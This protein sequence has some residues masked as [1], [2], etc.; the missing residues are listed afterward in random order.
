LSAVARF[1][2]AVIN[3]TSKNDTGQPARKRLI[4]NREA[5]PDGFFH[6]IDRILGTKLMHE[7]V[8][9]I[10]NRPD[11]P[12]QVNSN[13]PVALA[14]DDLS[15]N[16]DFALCES[17]SLVNILA[18]AI[19]NRPSDHRKKS[20]LVQRFFDKIY[21]PRFDGSYGHGNVSIPAE[22]KYAQLW[23]APFDPFQKL[24]AAGSGQVNVGN[25]QITVMVSQDLQTTVGIIKAADFAIV[26]LRSKALADRLANLRL[27]ID[28]KYHAFFCCC[29]HH[30]IFTPKFFVSIQTQK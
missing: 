26:N 14:L 3:K 15:Q 24:Q 22:Q 28:K 2:P 8:A 27:I 19:L 1:Y 21:S 4:V 29:F 7:P 9:V 17:F 25:N 13:L 20:C 5:Y 18:V 6:Q 10:L 23:A 16:P 12:A 11:G 30:L